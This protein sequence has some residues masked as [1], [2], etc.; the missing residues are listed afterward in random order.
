MTRT[1]FELLTGIYPS[2]DF[3]DMI[4]KVYAAYDGDKHAFC[5]AF[6]NN[7]DSMAQHIQRLADET[8]QAK[9]SAHFQALQAQNT[10]IAALK[11]QLAKAQA[12]LDEELEWRDYE[13]RKNVAQIQYEEL[14]S[15]PDINFL[16]EEEA[17]EVL[18]R[19]FGFAKEQVHIITDVPCRQINRHGKIRDRPLTLKR[20]PLYFSSD[21]NYIR[22]DCGLMSWEMLDG[23]LRPYLQ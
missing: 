16:T 10:E 21:M 14:K 11:Q 3:Y 12:A 8:A 20:F 9:V 6:R 18:Y 2:N 19:D 4:E 5:L 7:Q 22:F 15:T 13:D 17:K 1:E 23:E